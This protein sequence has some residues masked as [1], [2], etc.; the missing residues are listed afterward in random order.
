M[1]SLD[2]LFKDTDWAIQRLADKVG[3]DQCARFVLDALLIYCPGMF[4][5]AEDAMI[6]IADI[7]DEDCFNG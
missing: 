3:P 4:D 2:A 7:P 6:D 5:P 1:S